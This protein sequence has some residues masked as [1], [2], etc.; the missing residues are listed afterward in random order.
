MTR[1]EPGIRRGARLSTRLLLPLLAVVAAVMLPYAVWSMRQRAAV[2]V[3]EAERETRAYATAL[4]LALERAAGQNDPDAIQEMIDRI[5][6]DPSIYGVIVYDSLGMPQYV[7]SPLTTAPAASA[8]DIRAVL[9]DR[10]VSTLRREVLEESVV[11]LR[12]LMDEEGRVRGVLEVVQPLTPVTEQLARTRLR[13]LLNTATLLVAVTLLVLWS[14]RRYLSTP[15]AEF[16][17]AVRALGGGELTYRVEPSIAVGE[18]GEV[19]VELNRMADGLEKA[20][21]ELMTQ[22]EERLSLERRLLQSEKLAEVGQLA[23]GL[24]HEIGAPLHVIRGRADLVRRSGAKFD[25]AERH[26][27]V[28]VQEIDRIALI[29]RNLLGFVRRREP[30]VVAFDLVDV[31]RAVIDLLDVEMSRSS[32]GLVTEGLDARLKMQGDPDLLHQVFL[33]VL[34]NALHALEGAV[35]P[36]MVAV[37]L[38]RTGE[39]AMERAVIDIEDSGVGVP[40]SVRDH[41]FEPFY[42]TKERGQGTGLGLALARAIVE[43]HDGS[44]AMVQP[45]SAEWSTCVRITLA[46]RVAD[47]RRARFQSPPVGSAVGHSATIGSRE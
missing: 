20:R 26:L 4:G 36:R 15:L 45:S 47:G 24:A 46:T 9:S 28:I 30:K 6:R 27:G 8:D 23:A 29:V 39:G 41:V 31:L 5:D 7:S 43:D 32:V 40:P 22:S 3:A 16:M 21:Q 13:F 18:L 10:G 14:V 25:E 19:A 38:R 37:R 12:P 34:L 2:M 11:V 17:D 35:P 33:N 44:I 1:Q 42:T